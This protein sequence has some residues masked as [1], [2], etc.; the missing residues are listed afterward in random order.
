MYMYKLGLEKQ[1]NQKSNCQHSLNHR[2]S[3]GIPET[4]FF[5][6]ID[7]TKVSLYG[8]QQT[9]NFRKIWEY[10]T[11][12][13]ASW[14]TCVQV[15][16]QHL[17]LDMEQQS[18][19]KLGKGYIKAIYCHLPHLTFKQST[20]CE[21]PAWINNKLESRLSEKQQQPQICRWYHSN[22]RKWIELKSLLMRVKEEG[23]RSGLKLHIHKTKIMD[24]GPMTL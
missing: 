12:L 20:S 3:K 15:K 1:R 8:S 22:G 7:Y 14:K 10:Q 24:S 23:E 13:P 16:T 6:F 4:E 5:C 2:K 19:S 18:D 21:I 11:T 9:G 17:E